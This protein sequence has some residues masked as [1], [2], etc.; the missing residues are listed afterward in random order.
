MWGKKTEAIFTSLRP[1]NAIIEVLGEP[2]KKT[3][4]IFTSLRGGA[5]GHGGEVP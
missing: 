1:L 2:G 4:A 5:M 3:E